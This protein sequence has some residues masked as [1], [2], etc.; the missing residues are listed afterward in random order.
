MAKGGINPVMPWHSFNNLTGYFRRHNNKESCVRVS[1]RLQQSLW[2]SALVV[3]L[4]VVTPVTINSTWSD[5]SFQLGDSATT[6]QVI[7][8]LRHQSPAGTDK[9]SL[10]EARSALFS[11]RQA[12]ANS[13]VETAQAQCSKRAK[14]FAT[15]TIKATRRLTPKTVQSMI[16]RQLVTLQELRHQRTRNRCVQF[17]CCFAFLLTQAEAL[18]YY[19]DFETAENLG[20]ERARSFPVEFNAN[21]W[22]SR[23]TA[24]S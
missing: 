5:H 23:R 2:A 24:S 22:E 13:D 14:G 12:L 11:A 16:D 4:T 6:V 15:S 10:A 19:Q 3:S 17:W 20:Q 7:L 8:H 21:H 18:M 1:V 9:A